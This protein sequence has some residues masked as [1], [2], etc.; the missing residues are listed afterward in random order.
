MKPTVDIRDLS[1]VIDKKQILSS[2][3]AEIPVGKIVGLL[4]P[5]GAG[6][7]TLIRTILGLQKPASGSIS[8]LGLKAGSKKSKS[9]VGYVT[10]A[11]SVYSDLTVRENVQYFAALIGASSNQIAAVIKDVEMDEYAGRLVS[12]LSGG[13]KARVS[14]AV[15]LLGK[16][17][18]LLL[19]EPTVGLDPVLRQSLWSMFRNM[20]DVG[21][22]I[23]V[24][25]HVMDEADRC[26]GLLFLRDGKLLISDSKDAVLAKT[27]TSSMEAAFL[28]LVREGES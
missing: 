3:T 15:A 19:D 18:L 22:T 11:L 21:I 23:L 13:Q 27:K 2:I 6:K 24:S 8:V 4:G 25:S 14:L 1:V 10:Q 7:T 26:D 12:T 5:S 17:K 28:S 20:A 9:Q 16:P